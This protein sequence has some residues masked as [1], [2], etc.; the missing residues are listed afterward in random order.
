MEC[1]ANYDSTR[2]IYDGKTW[3][4]TVWGGYVP[5]VD[6]REMSEAETLSLAKL[7][8]QAARKAASLDEILE[9][10]QLAQGLLGALAEAKERCAEREADAEARAKEAAEAEAAEAVETATETAEAAE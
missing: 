3:K 9:Y 6:V 4:T 5:K 10:A 7:C 8:E 1:R 2:V